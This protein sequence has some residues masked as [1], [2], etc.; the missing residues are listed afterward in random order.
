LLTRGA[1]RTPDG[2]RA[3]A[4]IA[5]QGAWTAGHLLTDAPDDVRNAPARE[6]DVLY[7]GALSPD[8]IADRA[9]TAAQDATWATGALIRVRACVLDALQVVRT[10]SERR[11]GKT[12]AGVARRLTPMNQTMPSRAAAHQPRGGAAPDVDRIALAQ[13]AACDAEAAVKAL[14]KMPAYT[15][16]RLPDDTLDGLIRRAAQTAEAAADA[17]VG[18]PPHGV[19]RLPEEAVRALAQAAARKAEWSVQ[20]LRVRM[21][22]RRKKDADL[23]AR[24]RRPAKPPRRCA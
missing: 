22:Q 5:G 16:E 6:P 9:R 15:V 23:A 1:D 4:R 3:P 19:A 10:S 2:I 14:S 17:P 8:V 18:M 24:M 7:G 20:A 13:A 12:H 21:A 11:L